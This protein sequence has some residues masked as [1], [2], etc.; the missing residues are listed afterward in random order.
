MESRGIWPGYVVPHYGLTLGERGV[1]HRR[2]RRVTDVVFRDT[3]RAIAKEAPVTVPRGRMRLGRYREM[4]ARVGIRRLKEGY[5]GEI[6]KDGEIHSRP[7]M[8]TA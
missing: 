6:V 8:G 2:S 3:T 5:P 4:H 7:Q 1:K